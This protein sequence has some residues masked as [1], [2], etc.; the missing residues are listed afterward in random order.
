MSKDTR[1]EEV[2]KMA[3]EV[4]GDDVKVEVLKVTPNK[5][6]DTKEETGTPITN[7]LISD[8]EKAQVKVL[9]ETF[10]KLMQLHKI[11]GR[12]TQILSAKKD[13]YTMLQY[14]MYSD[15]IKDA[16]NAIKGLNYVCHEMTKEHVDEVSRENDMTTTEM[17]ASGMMHIL[18]EILSK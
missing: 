8:E 11:D 1:I 3:K 9:V 12:L 7:S 10:D 5:E 6:E 14:L 17:V 2:V 15:H 18:S 13:D 4:F 16:I